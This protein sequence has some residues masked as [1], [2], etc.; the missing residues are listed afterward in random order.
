MTRTTI[1]GWTLT[2]W[3]DDPDVD[4]DG[5]NGEAWQVSGSSNE[6]DV[7]PEDDERGRGWDGDCVKTRTIPIAVLVAALRMAGVVPG[8]ETETP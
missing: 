7:S 3:G 2:R 5:P 4:I 8:E 1:D 6:V